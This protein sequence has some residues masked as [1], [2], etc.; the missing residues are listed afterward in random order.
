MYRQTESPCDSVPPYLLGPIENVRARLSRQS[1]ARPVDKP[2]AC[3]GL[4]EAARRLR[5]HVEALFALGARPSAKP[6]LRRS[7]R[8]RRPRPID[9]PGFVD[10]NGRPARHGLGD[11]RRRYGRPEGRRRSASLAGYGR[12]GCQTGWTA[13]P[14]RFQ[15][16]WA[17]PSGLMVAAVA[18]LPSPVASAPVVR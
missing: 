8:S 6:P 1:P 5:G 4:D 9:G 11:G 17:D 10:T 18:A 14:I 15:Q 13:A 16:G 12:K 2:P 3:R 7:C